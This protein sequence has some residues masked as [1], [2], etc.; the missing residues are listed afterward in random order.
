M[1]LK[2]AKIVLE[3]KIIEN[4]YLII[5][6]KKIKTIGEGTT[7]QEGT[8]LKGKIVM[9]GFIDCHV[10]GGYGVDF[11]VGD[12][13][14][15][16]TFAKNVSQ[17]GITRYYQ[18]PISNSV[19]DNDRY[20]KEFGDYMSRT[21]KTGSIC[22]GAHMEGPFISPEKKGAH[23]PELLMAPNI[24]Y[25]KRW[26]DLCGGNIKIITYAGELQDGSFTTYLLENGILPSIGHTD[27]ESWEFEK[28]YKL[29]AK[30]VT[31]LFNGMSGVDQRR[32]GLA[33]AAM[34][35]KDVMCEVISDGI[36]IQSD[37]LKLILKTVGVDNICIITDA[38]NAKGLP[39]GKYKIG[40]L[41]VEK[42]GITVKLTSNGS[43]AGAGA[44]Y[45]HNVRVYKETC[46]LDL[47]SLSKMSATNIAK[48][49]K[50]DNITGSISENKFADL[51]ILDSDLNVEMTIVEGNIVYKK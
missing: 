23:D 16:D 50:I 30:H 48:Q 37:T 7:D 13:N 39:D 28:D 47:I 15:F 8:D 27:M 14:R 45:D 2:N 26:N 4:G 17:E 12:L 18:G 49:M 40:E 25:T 35:K 51:V 20:F 9:P 3:N 34:N 5:E 36:H 44:T 33:T 29:G 11:E 31:H 21:D 1:L 42:V 24:E 38:M 32:P 41:E 6:D 46:D 22:M 43:L 10:H 19:A